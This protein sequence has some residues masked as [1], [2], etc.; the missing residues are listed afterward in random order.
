MSNIDACNNKPTLKD[1]LKAIKK[2]TSEERR[3]IEK[4]LVLMRLSN[5][6]IYISDKLEKRRKDRKKGETENV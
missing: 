3:I 6:F 5:E 1:I 4:E 2:L